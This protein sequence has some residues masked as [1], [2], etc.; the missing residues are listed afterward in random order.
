M[1]W[2][3]NKKNRAKFFIFS[4]K[5]LRSIIPVY[6]AVYFFIVF[7]F[8]IYLDRD[9]ELNGKKA[10]GTVT[11]DK[12]NEGK[13]SSYR[14][15]KVEYSNNEIPY[16][17][18][19]VDEKVKIGNKIEVYYSEISPKHSI[20]FKNKPLQK[21]WDEGLLRRLLILYFIGSVFASLAYYFYKYEDGSSILLSNRLKGN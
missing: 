18:W 9:L 20:L 6:V 4:L 3:D 8:N 13:K 2:L 14:T 5:F 1:G 15:I 7:P 11:L 17:K 16:E 19:F 10:I 12:I 21:P